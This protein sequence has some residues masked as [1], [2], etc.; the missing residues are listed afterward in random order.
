MCSERLSLT[1]ESKAESLPPMHFIKLH[2]SSLSSSFIVNHQN[3]NISST[4]GR[5]WSG[6]HA[7]K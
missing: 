6:D 3:V 4:R 2:I 1:I 5:P 7:L